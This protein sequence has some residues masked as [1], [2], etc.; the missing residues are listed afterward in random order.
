MP[1]PPKDVLVS[2]K[3]MGRRLRAIRLK[4]GLKQSEVAD[5]LGVHFTVVSAVERGV[6]ALTLQQMAKMSKALRISP[7]EL[8]SPGPV[9][10]PPTLTRR[11]SQLLRRV[12]RIRELPPAQQRTVL[13]VLDSRLETHASHDRKP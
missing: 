6:R 7:N 10:E 8:L 5:A 11:D 9:V 4:R 13:D 12:G 1:K 3:E 2:K